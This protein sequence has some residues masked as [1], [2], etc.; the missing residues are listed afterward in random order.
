M[1]KYMDSRKFKPLKTEIIGEIKADVLVVLDKYN[2]SPQ[3]RIG[4]DIFEILK[5]EGFLIFH[6]FEDTRVWGVFISKNN[7]KYFV[8]N[9]SLKLEEMIFA[10][11]HEYAHSRKIA[12]REMEILTG[13]QLNEYLNGSEENGSTEEIERKASR[14]AAELLVNGKK[15]KNYI[16]DEFN[17]DELT[18]MHVLKLSE[19]FLVPYKTI[20]RRLREEN[21][22]DEEN[23]YDFEE[24]TKEKL[25][26]TT[27]R[28]ELCVKNNL[29]SK[30]KRYGEYTNM[31][32]K[33][34]ENDLR[35]YS[36]LKEML[37]LLKSVPSDFGIDEETD[38][39]DFM[40]RSFEDGE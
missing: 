6:P 14:F 31:L 34:Y 37:E 38:I 8:I 3:N 15:L 26:F 18:L 7:E 36:E 33:L 27:N 20:V 10:A 32:L 21:I 16:D 28:Y 25:K 13:G 40:I 23:F 30:E 29:I 19:Y 9:S 2:L 35:T 22:I 11:A 1:L 5:K 24:I 39:F 12:Y 4:E 17:G